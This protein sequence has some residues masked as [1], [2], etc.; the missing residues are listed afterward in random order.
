MGRTR[1]ALAGVLVIAAGCGAHASI[2]SHGASSPTNTHGATIASST[3]LR[4][5]SLVLTV[6]DL[7]PAYNQNA[8]ATGPLS[9]AQV[10]YGDDRAARTTLRRFWIRSYEAGFTTARTDKPGVWCAV[11]LFRSSRLPGLAHSWKLDARRQLTRPRSLPVPSSAPGHPL[12]LV[13]GEMT[14]LGRRVSVVTYGWQRG[15]LLAQLTVASEY[16]RGLTTATL[17]FAHLEDQRVKAYGSNH[18]LG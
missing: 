6:N 10:A 16:G 5:A 14:I 4:L 15:H 8:G 12:W 17:R 7:G 9:F 11:H 3:K 1:I 13:H 2:G 18:A